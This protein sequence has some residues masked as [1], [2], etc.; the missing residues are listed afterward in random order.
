[1]PDARFMEFCQGED[2]D[3][4]TACWLLAQTQYP[5]IDVR[6]YQSLL[7]AWAD[8]LS[9]RI[10]RQEAPSAILSVMN[11]YVFSTLGFAGNQEH[12][13]DPRNS[14]LN[15]V[16][17]RRLGIPISLCVIYMALARRLNLPIVGIGMPGHFM[18]CYQ[19]PADDIYIDAFHGGRLLT[20]ADCIMHL[21]KTGQEYNERSLWPLS[22]R[23]ILQRACSNLYHIYQDLGEAE[24]MSRIQQFIV[25]LSR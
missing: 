8:E 21:Q 13:Y 24:K 20:R 16:M 15:C 4:E 3:V 18:C 23:R 25:Y 6:A 1:M 7:D 11:L 19:R 17:D 2:F 22:S 12:Y 14:Y 9:Q 10:D 5:D